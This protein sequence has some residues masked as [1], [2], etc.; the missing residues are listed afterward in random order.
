LGAMISIAVHSSEA[1][2][3][4]PNIPRILDFTFFIAKSTSEKWAVL[5]DENLCCLNALEKYLRR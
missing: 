1:A 5:L 4:G 2:T 3:A